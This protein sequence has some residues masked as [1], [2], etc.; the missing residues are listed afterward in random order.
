MWTHVE[1][2]ETPPKCDYF[3]QIYPIHI[4]PSSVSCVSFVDFTRSLQIWVR[5]WCC[6]ERKLQLP[7][8]R[9]GTPPGRRTWRTVKFLGILEKQLGI[10]W[11]MADFGRFWKILEEMSDYQPQISYFE[12]MTLF[13]SR[14][15][16]TA[17]GFSKMNF[18]ERSW[19]KDLRVGRCLESV[20]QHFKE[21]HHGWCQIMSNLFHEQLRRKR[22]RLIKCH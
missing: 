6:Q 11:N 16:F 4:F 3:T 13:L 14:S 7:A 20:E 8:L 2:T 5:L 19:K 9:W 17:P 21:V 15:M 10:W 22:Q 18:V 1:G 12:V